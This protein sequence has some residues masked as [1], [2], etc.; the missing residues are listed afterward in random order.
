MTPADSFIRTICDASTIVPG[1]G[2]R[3]GVG[4]GVTVGEGLGVGLPDGDGESKLVLSH[5]RASW[6]RKRNQRSFFFSFGWLE[7]RRSVARIERI[8]W[9]RVLLARTFTEIPASGIPVDGIW[10]SRLL[11]LERRTQASSVPCS[12]RAAYSRS[13]K[14]ATEMSVRLAVAGTNI[15]DSAT[16]VAEGEAIAKI[17]SMRRHRLRTE[18]SL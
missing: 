2:V 3:V 8:V 14:P 9:R 6:R 13:S 1:G 18:S 4:V 15:R 7:D 5:D 10:T 17:Q 12:L 16:R 11:P